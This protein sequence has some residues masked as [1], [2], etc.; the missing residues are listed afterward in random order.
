MSDPITAPASAR[1][2]TTLLIM[3][4]DLTGTADSAVACSSAGLTTR[5]LLSATSRH[6]TRVVAIDTDSRGCTPAQAARRNRECLEHWRDCHDHLYKKMDSTLRGNVAAELAALIPL[7]GMAIVAPAF[8]ATGRTTRQGRQYL[9][10]RPVEA[11]EVWT[12]EGM[13]GRADLVTMLEEAGLTTALLTLDDLHQP[14]DVVTQQLAHWQREGIQAVVCDALTRD[15][16]L[17]V[18]RASVPLS[19]VFWAG[20]AGLGEALPEALRL[21]PATAATEPPPADSLPG[22]VLIVIGSM[23]SVSHR[24]ADA[25]QALARDALE[26]VSLEASLLRTAAS[27][28]EHDALQQHIEQALLAGRDVLVRLVQG[29]D[30]NALEAP[31]L[32]NRLG[33]LLAPLLPHVSRLIATGGATARAILT[34]ADIVELTLLDAPDIGMARMKGPGPQSLEVITKAGGFGDPDA[35][36]RLWHAG[37]AN[38]PQQAA[39]N[40]QE[41]HT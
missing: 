31:Q 29:K 30:R 3:A 1:N 2:C 34:A 16:L 8:P 37:H 15:D 11:C 14:L 26:I 10:D 27:G 20:S 36:A 21:L 41:S 25:L 28:V 39:T 13:T 32:S 40:Y 35:L 6:P 22:P 24:Q 17:Q 9:D 19:T 7:A 4:D 38:C 5:V 12:N 23:S 18:A 33:A